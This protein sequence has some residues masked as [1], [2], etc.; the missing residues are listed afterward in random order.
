VP[1]PRNDEAAAW[2]PK[3]PAADAGDK[4]LGSVAVAVD[5]GTA[6][7]LGAYLLRSG[8]WNRSSGGWGG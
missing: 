1:V 6:L 7:I 5:K 8:S 4:T 2:R 3:A